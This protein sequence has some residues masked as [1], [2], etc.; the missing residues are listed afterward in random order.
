MQA[1]QSSYEKALF[2]AANQYYSSRARGGGR[3]MRGGRGRGG[4]GGGGRPNFSQNVS[5]NL[6]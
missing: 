5:C 2:N 1:S 6:C 4:G 3:G